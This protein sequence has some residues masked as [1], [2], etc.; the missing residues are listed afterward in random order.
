MY[1]K[2]SNQLIVFFF[3]N[4]G[5]NSHYQVQLSKKSL[6]NRDEN[7]LRVRLIILMCENLFTILFQAEIDFNLR[8]FEPNFTEFVRG[9]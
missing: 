7:F 8:E 4:G 1:S 2:V 9:T 6:T 5:G 3:K